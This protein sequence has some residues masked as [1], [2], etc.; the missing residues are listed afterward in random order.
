MLERI[1]QS[2][3]SARFAET[4]PAYSAVLLDPVG[5]LWVEQFRWIDANERSPIASNA[6][7]SVFDPAGVWL[8]NVEMPPGFILREVTED[9]VLGFVID[10]LDAK[11][12]HAYPLDRRA[13]RE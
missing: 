5:D 4:L 2:L 9:R 12:I 10:E 6:Q 8:G 13:K 11:E 1:R 3:E 7:W